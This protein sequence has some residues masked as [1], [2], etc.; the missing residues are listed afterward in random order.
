MT[1]SPILTPGVVL[2]QGV[3]FT[4]NKFSLSLDARYQGAS[5]LDFAN[6]EQLDGYFLLNART[7]Y[8]LGPVQLILRVNNL[9]NVSY[10]NNGYVDFDLTP[11]YFLQAPLNFRASAVW[12]F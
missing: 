11:K 2:N 12:R 5:W 4:W 3:T 6:T 10:Y 7:S 8:Q 1:F 9:T